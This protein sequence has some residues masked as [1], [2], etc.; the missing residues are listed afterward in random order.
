[1]ENGVII[2]FDNNLVH[3]FGI[4]LLVLD[5]VSVV[6][7]LLDVVELNWDVA[8]PEVDELL[9]VD[10][11]LVVVVV[12]VVTIWLMLRFWV[13]RIKNFLFYQM[14]DFFW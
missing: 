5:S 13:A 12:V 14:I 2:F 4:Q 3:C 11:E 9:F 8:V 10:V 6:E 1:M 7:L